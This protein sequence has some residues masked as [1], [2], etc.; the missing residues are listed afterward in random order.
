MLLLVHEST[1][2]SAGGSRVVNGNNS[3]ASREPLAEPVSRK[4]LAAAPGAW[5]T[6]GSKR[7]A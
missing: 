4:R 7:G 3:G 1:P 5:G 2:I 6:F